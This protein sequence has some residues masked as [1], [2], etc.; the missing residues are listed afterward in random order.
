[1]VIEHF[2]DGAIDL[3]RQRHSQE[4]RMLPASISYHASWVDVTGRRCFQL[5]ESSNPDDLEL[6]TSR[7]SDL[8]DFEIIPVVSSSG[9]WNK[10]NIN[11]SPT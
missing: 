9:F 1:M 2:K 10:E 6:W 4:G 8:I 11:S 3:I 5:L 7:W